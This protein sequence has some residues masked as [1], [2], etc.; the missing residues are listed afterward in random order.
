MIKSINRITFINILSS[1][2]L[3][4]IAFFTTPVFTNLLGTEQYG[5]FSVYNAWIGIVTCIMGLG[6]TS[7]LGT[8]RYTFKETYYEYR[9]S[10][11]L[12]S[13]LLSIGIVGICLLFSNHLSKVI[14]IKQNLIPVLLATSFAQSIVTYI[15]STYIYEKKAISNLVL[16]VCLSCSTVILSVLLIQKAEKDALYIG[17]IYGLAIPYVTIAVFLWFRCFLK[18]PIGIKSNYVKF[19]LTV[20][21]PVVFHALSHTILNQSDRVMMQWMGI[22]NSEIGI[23]SLFYTMSSIL[24]VILTALNTSWCP[25]YYDGISENDWDGLASKSKHYIETF[26]SLTVG[27][28]LVGKEISEIMS[29]NDFSTGV[30]ILPILTVSVYFT[31]M[32]QFPTNYEFYHKKTKIIAFGTVSSGALNVLL[33]YF[34]I[35]VYGMYGAAIATAISYLMLYFLHYIVVMKM[36]NNKY[37]LPITKFATGLIAVVFGTVVFYFFK[38]FWQVRWIFGI[39]IGTWELYR[40]IKRKGVF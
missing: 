34:F 15:Q 9:S 37:H 27:F 12:L 22:S 18:K 40:M 25:F 20:G 7:A 6:V 39:T 10:T 5:I 36:T 28:L 33:N 29:S 4:G 1:L 24:S 19:G 31:F 13:T 3:Q 2:V 32:Y 30:D 16:S 38:D 21:F 8:G 11:L 14:K 17:R 26:T 35:P 23:Y